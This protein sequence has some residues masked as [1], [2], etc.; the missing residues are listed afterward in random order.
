MQ[1]HRQFYFGAFGTHLKD[2]QTISVGML[3]TLRNLRSCVRGAQILEQQVFGSL[4]VM[5]NQIGAQ[6]ALDVQ[7]QQSASVMSV[8]NVGAASNIRFHEGTAV[9]SSLTLF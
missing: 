8:Y 7:Y 1:L 3:A 6:A 2:L 4:G 9:G 5:N